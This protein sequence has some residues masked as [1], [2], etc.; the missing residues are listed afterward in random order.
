MKNL[1]NTKLGLAVTLFM[2]FNY[3]SAQ[4]KT[5]YGYSYSTAITKNSK[6]KMVYISNIIAVVIDSKDFKDSV[7]TALSNQWKEAVQGEDKEAYHNS[8]VIYGFSKLNNKKAV[9]KHRIK[10]MTEFHNSGY[11]IMVLDHFKFLKPKN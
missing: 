3:T 11:I 2:V 5:T 8:P 9:E 10:L 6:I 7:S 1:T 4:K